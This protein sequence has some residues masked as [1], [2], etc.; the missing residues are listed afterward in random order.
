MTAYREQA[1]RSRDAAQRIVLPPL[2]QLIGVEGRLIALEGAERSKDPRV[3]MFDVVGG[4]DFIVRTPTR[5]ITIASR[6]QW[7]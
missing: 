7:L 6:V 5:I 4:V 1:E 3:E 2:L